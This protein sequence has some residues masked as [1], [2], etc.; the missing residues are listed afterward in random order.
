[1][2]VVVKID[3]LLPKWKGC[4]PLGRETIDF[5]TETVH[6]WQKHHGNS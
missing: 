1:M 3:L 6:L 2:T 5:P 4:L